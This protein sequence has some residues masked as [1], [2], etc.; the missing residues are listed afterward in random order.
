[1]IRFIDLSNQITEGIKEFTFYDT[2]T[3]KFLVFSDCQTWESIDNFKEDY[4][5]DDLERYLK[6]IP[7]KF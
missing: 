1:M 6:L 7:E 4:T 5:G 2:I 3:D